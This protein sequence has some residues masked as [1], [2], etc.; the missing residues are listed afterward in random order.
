MAAPS[1][2][3]HVEK[4]E[5]SSSSDSQSESGDSGQSD[6]EDVEDEELGENDKEIQVDFE[7]QS[8]GAEDFSGIKSLLNQLFLKAHINFS[9]L[10]D[11]IIAQNFVG[12]VLK[13]LSRLTKIK[14]AIGYHFIGSVQQCVD[15]DESS[16]DEDS[17]NEVFGI[18]SV[19]NLTYHKVE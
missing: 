14:N 1:K 16:D 13:V 19:I 12:S 3:R 17:V 11:L 6:N 4:E 7:G 15:E 10:A 18:S 2:K 9:Q 8:P 5:S